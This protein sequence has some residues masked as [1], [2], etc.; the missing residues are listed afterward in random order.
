MATLSFGHRKA[1][2]TLL[3]VLHSGLSK[4]TINFGCRI[5]SFLPYLNSL[6]PLP[7]GV[8]PG[9]PGSF[10][11]IYLVFLPGSFSFWYV[12]HQLTET[13]S[14][15]DPSAM[16]LAW[17]LEWASATKEWITHQQRQEIYLHQEALQISK[18][19]DP[20]AKIQAQTAKTNVEAWNY[21]SKGL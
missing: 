4:I 9:P 10:P 12:T 16:A 7:P 6:G 14:T 11:L 2:F 8:N 19:L 18:Q 20:R 17:N 15:R 1:I 13:R 3:S 21:F 5:L